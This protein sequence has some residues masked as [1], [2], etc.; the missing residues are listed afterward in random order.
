MAVLH[1]LAV[2]VLVIVFTGDHSLLPKRRN[3][4]EKSRGSIPALALRLKPLATAKKDTSS[5]LSND[6]RSVGA[7]YLLLTHTIYA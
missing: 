5:M 6:V 3:K 7:R 1:F 2:L 4:N